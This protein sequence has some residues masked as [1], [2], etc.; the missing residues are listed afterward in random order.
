MPTLTPDYVTQAE[1][2]QGR[3]RGDPSLP[4]DEEPEV[5]DEE[6]EEV[7]TYIH[8]YGRTDVHTYLRAEHF[9]AFHFH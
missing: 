6:A 8:T 7:R 4:L 3:L 1:A 9:V 2:V 5:E